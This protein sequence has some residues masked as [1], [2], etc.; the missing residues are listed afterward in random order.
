MIP[1]VGVLIHSCPYLK[2]DFCLSLWFLARLRARLAPTAG[3]S[4]AYRQNSQGCRG[5]ASCLHSQ[6]LFVSLT[7]CFL[8]PSLLLCEN[9]LPSG[10]AWKSWTPNRVLPPDGLCGLPSLFSL[11]GYSIKMPAPFA[12]I[13]LRG[14]LLLSLRS[15][16]AWVFI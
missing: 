7:P 13:A 2:S 10:R 1:Y 16:A 11:V 6:L 3:N 5:G 4:W 15:N 12:L 14:C 9:G 8:G